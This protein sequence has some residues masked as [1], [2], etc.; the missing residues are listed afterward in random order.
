MR[1]ELSCI[2]LHNHA[3]PCSCSAQISVAGFYSP[4]RNL[5]PYLNIGWWHNV[6][7][8]ATTAAYWDLTGSSLLCGCIPLDTGGFQT[9]RCAMYVCKHISTVALFRVELLLLRVSVVT[10][11]GSFRVNPCTRKEQLW[12]SNCRCICANL[13]G[14]HRFAMPSAGVSSTQLTR[15]IPGSGDADVHSC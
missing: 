13:D 3:H 6:K 10:C 9:C 8:T 2:G 1:S 15:A 14:A 12:L 5:A 7:D 11:K 4:T